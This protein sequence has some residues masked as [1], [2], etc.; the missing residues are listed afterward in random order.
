MK[1]ELVF[2]INNLTEKTAMVETFQ[3]GKRESNAGIVIF[4]DFILAVDPTTNYQTA[5]EYRKKLEMEF[6]LPVKYLFITHHDGD[7]VFGA[8]AFKDSIIVGHQNLAKRLQSKIYNEWSEIKSE[9]V[10]PQ[11]TFKEKVII[12][13]NDVEVELH[14]AGGHSDCSS[15]GYFPK[16]KVL[17]AGDLVFSRMFPWAGDITSSPDQ[18]INT[19]QKFLDMDIRFLVPGHG[20]LCGKNEIRKHLKHFEELRGIVLDAVSDETDISSIN[21]PEFYPASNEIIV[22][23][24]LTHYYKYYAHRKCVAEVKIW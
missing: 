6:N 1:M 15:Y 10:L 20:P 19:L 3:N 8:L 2:N 18:W 16:E 23:K 7:H 21:R 5:I 14:H 11:I 22:S 17:F 12:S 13:N 24:T 9:I 4:D